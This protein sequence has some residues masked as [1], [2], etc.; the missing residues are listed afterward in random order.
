MFSIHVFVK[1]GNCMKQVSVAYVF[2]SRRSKKD[3]KKVFKAILDLVPD[4]R[5]RT[6]VADFEAASWNA[7]RELIPNIGVK[8]CL[9]HF[10]Q[11]VYGKIGNI[12]L[13]HAYANDPGTRK[14]CR[15][16][17]ALPILP[18]DHIVRA[19]YKLT[20]F[21]VEADETVGPHLL[22]RLD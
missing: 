5:L 21:V 11:A 1:E 9:F 18:K 15:Q 12:G 8:G 16:L 3:Y 6:M 19:F 2:M 14:L 4:C 20:E 13:K 7:K 10:T 22:K 17:M